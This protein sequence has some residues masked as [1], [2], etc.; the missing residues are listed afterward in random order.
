MLI[1]LHMYLFTVEQDNRAAVILRSSFGFCAA[2]GKS[3]VRYGHTAYPI[4]KNSRVLQLI[5]TVSGNCDIA[6]NTIGLCIVISATAVSDA[7]RNTGTAHI[8]A[9][10]AIMMEHIVANDHFFTRTHFAPSCHITGN[11]NRLMGDIGEDTILQ[12]DLICLEQNTPGS[13]SVNS[14]VAHHR[15]R[16]ECH[17][18]NHIS[19]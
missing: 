5:K 6:M 2:A 19:G 1:F 11:L 9:T 13:G 4:R 18:G 8:L 15:I 14:A 12:Q 7:H 16:A 3:I 10:Q 17:I